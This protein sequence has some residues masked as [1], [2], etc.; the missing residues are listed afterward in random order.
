MLLFSQCLHISFI[1]SSPFQCSRGRASVTFLM[2][3]TMKNSR[4]FKRIENWNVGLLLVTFCI[5]I[6]FVIFAVFYAYTSSPKTCEKLHFF[7]F[8]LSTSHIL[9]RLSSILFLFSDSNMA[10][11]TLF[12][13]T[14]KPYF[15]D[16][17]GN[18]CIQHTVFDSLKACLITLK[19]FWQFPTLSG[20]TFQHVRVFA[21]SCRC[22]RNDFFQRPR[23]KILGLTATGFWSNSQEVAATSCWN[24]LQ[25]IS[26]SN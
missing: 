5:F 15:C 3:K 6:Y 23:S 19:S 9:I 22:V 11:C 21:R 24:Y 13:K 12:L 17:Q 20:G 10:T 16:L 14:R 1:N 4:I 18:L 26:G 7:L 2:R 25:Q 8:L